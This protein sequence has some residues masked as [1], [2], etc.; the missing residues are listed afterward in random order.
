MP[1]RSAAALASIE[2]G[3]PVP[4][5]GRYQVPILYCKTYCTENSIILWL[6]IGC[7]WF[8]ESCR[9]PVNPLCGSRASLLFVNYIYLSTSVS[10]IK[11]RSLN[12]CKLSIRIRCEKFLAEFIWGF[13]FGRCDPFFWYVFSV[14]KLWHRPWHLGGH[15][16][17][18]F[19]AVW[20]CGI[21]IMWLW[22]Q[23]DGT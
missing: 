15:V 3:S 16:A 18:V 8:G 2:I 4:V 5:P 10:W 11:C 20:T 9:R 22:Y 21:L 19:R 1:A 13:W 7:S 17:K 6:V 23:N 14:P 12:I